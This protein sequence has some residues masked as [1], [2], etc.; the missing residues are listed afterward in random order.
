MMRPGVDRLY[1]SRVAKNAACGP[2]YPM[3]TPNRCELPTTM[4]AP[5]SPGD[6]IRVNASKSLATTA[7][8]PFLWA[9]EIASLGFFR[10]PVDAG[11]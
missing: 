4:S 10:H 5:I 6:L 3:G 9:W 8:A 7:N 1:S 2:P 11:Y